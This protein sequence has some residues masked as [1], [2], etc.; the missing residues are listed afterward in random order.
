MT[1]AREGF[2]MIPFVR[3]SL[4]HMVGKPPPRGASKYLGIEV[5]FNTLSSRSPY[6]EKG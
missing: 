5:Y 4:F 6:E 1:G 3:V 2:K